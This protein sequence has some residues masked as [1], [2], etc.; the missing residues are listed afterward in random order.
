M[1][2]VA[3]RGFGLFELVVACV[4]F[5]TLAGLLLQRLSF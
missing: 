5:A 2:R 4:I 3:Q 1:K